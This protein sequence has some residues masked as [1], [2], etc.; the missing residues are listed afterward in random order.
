MQF[1][2]NKVRKLEFLLADA[3][4]KGYTTVLTYGG[5]AS[6]HIVATACYAHQ[7][8]LQ[9]IGLLFKQ[10]PTL[11]IS[12]NLLLISITMHI[13]FSVRSLDF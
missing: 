5:Y 12:R 4:A 10:N 1:G 2:G 7:L 13:F 9:T 11:N 8:G 6:N 3:I